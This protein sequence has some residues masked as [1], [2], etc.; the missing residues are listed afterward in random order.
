MDLGVSNRRSEQAEAGAVRPVRVVVADDHTLFRVGLARLLADDGRVDVVAMAH[1]GE[2]AV[3]HAVSQRPD[4]VLMDLHIPR[5]NGVDAT[6]RIAQEAPD[7]RVVVLT[8]L[9]DSAMVRDA[10]DAGAVSV[11]AKD[12]TF[13]D[14]VGVILASA[15]P[16]RTP[17]RPGP[18]RFS[19]REV[20]VVKELANGLSNKQI[21][22]RLGISE[23][24]VRNHLSRIFT[25]CGA[26]NRTEVVM[27][28]MRTGIVFA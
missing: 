22:R 11:L 6:R 5:L 1:D 2:E 12:V 28:A 4:V 9:A 10:L 20:H 15:S 26:S 23:K 14:A 17:R 3:E 19:E 8:A 24:T 13:D 27:H 7:V 25:K 18:G 21:A 16:S